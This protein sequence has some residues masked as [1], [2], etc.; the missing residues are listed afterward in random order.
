MNPDNPEPFIER[1][2]QLCLQ[3]SHYPGQK[4]PASD[5]IADIKTPSLTKRLSPLALS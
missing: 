2:D 1:S 4:L 5:L 3:Q